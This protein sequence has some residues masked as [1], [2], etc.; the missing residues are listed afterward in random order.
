[1]GC[2]CCSQCQC[3]N[4]KLRDDLR[5]LWSDHVCYTRE[6][7]ISSTSNLPDLEFVAKRLMQNPKDFTKVLSN[8]YSIKT[9]VTFEKEFT[10]HLT[11]AAEIVTAAKS[12]QPID[13]LQKKWI[14]NANRVA[15]SLS[16]NPK[17]YKKWHDMML[18]H[19]KL[20]ENELV[21]RLKGQ[22]EEDIKNFDIIYTEALAMGDMMAYNIK[23]KL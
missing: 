21:F 10:E 12:N 5:K 1:M 18:H 17:E 8:F 22:Y 2:G 13:E 15:K 6:F 4:T 3:S 16:I 14:A 20:T 23:H 11:I 9:V 19:L 7:I